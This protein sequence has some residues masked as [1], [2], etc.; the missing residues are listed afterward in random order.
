MIWRVMSRWDGMLVLCCCM[1][2][3]D[4]VWIDRG[5]LDMAGLGRRE[6]CPVTARPLG[7]CASR[8]WVDELHM[9]W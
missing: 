4:D 3:D 6:S 7:C 2:A 8:H 1:V 9:S 5:A